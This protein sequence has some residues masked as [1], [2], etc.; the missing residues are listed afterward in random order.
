MFDFF[1]LFFC[2][3]HDLIIRVGSAIYNRIS[4]IQHLFPQVDLQALSTLSPNLLG[5]C[6]SHALFESPGQLFAGFLPL[7]SSFLLPPPFFLVPVPF[8]LPPFLLL[9][10]PFLEPVLLPWRRELL[11]P[12]LLAMELRLPP[13]AFLGRPAL[14]FWEPPPFRL[15]LLLRL[16]PFRL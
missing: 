2:T 4:G 10:P 7:A 1:H 13:P 15:T 8:L 12:L 16:P 14:P 6:C 9:P 5:H 3:G 11:P